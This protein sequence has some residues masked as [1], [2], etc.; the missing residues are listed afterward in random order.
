MQISKDIRYIGVDDHQ[1]DLFEGQYIVPLGMAYN[2]YVILDEKIAVMDTVDCNFCELWIEKLQ[3]ALCGKS[4]DYLVIHHMEP[5]HSGS[6]EGFL[7]EFPQAIL[8]GNKK[9]FT[10]LDQFYPELPK[11]NRLT[12]NTGDELALGK[13][14]LRF[15]MA[16]MV[17]WP[18]VMVSYDSFD[19]VLFSADAFGKFGANDVED[20]EGWACEARRYYFGIVGKYGAQVQKLLQAVSEM[21]IEAICP[22]HG[23]VIRDDLEYC[24]GL[25]RK[26]S[27]YEPEQEGV[28]IAYTSVYGNTKMAVEYLSD[29][30]QELGC[31]KVSVMDLARDDMPETVEDAFR[32]SKMVLATTTYNGD[33]FP[34]MKT[35]LDHL[36]ERNYQNRTVAFIEN[37]TWAPMAAK[38]MAETL[39]ECINL[40]FSENTV[41]IR[42]AMTAENREDLD[43][44]ANELA[45][46]AEHEAAEPSENAQSLKK[47]VCTICGYIYEGTELPED[48]ECPLCHMDASFFELSGE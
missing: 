37:G 11:E 46:D 1:L 16:P 43:R 13:H 40:S 2:S 38:V 4:P 18:E 23:P 25:Y 34:W 29:R 17:H 44:L 20:P 14:S 12:V 47:W 7:R 31:P 48:F 3:D 21:E 36:K 35:F 26:W 27:A 19:R 15:L 22:L 42:S 41:T 9:T 5:D 33:V 39:S 10:M 28:L 30:L 32:Y 6:I 24:L 8:V 45:G